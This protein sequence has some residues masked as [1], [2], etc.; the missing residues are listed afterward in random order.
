MT[1]LR[2]VLLLLIGLAATGCAAITEPL[3]MK[4]P[5]AIETPFKDVA[6]NDM[7]LA[8]AIE[9]P[10]VVIDAPQG[11]SEERAV[12]LRNGIVLAARRRDLPASTEPMA[13]AWVLS[14][15]AATISNPDKKG[16]P[17][18]TGVLS[19]RLIDAAGAEKGAFVVSFEGGEAALTETGVRA[20]AEQ[21]ASALEA[22]L[23]RPGTQVTEVAAASVTKPKAWIGAIK[24]APGDGNKALTQALQ[25]ILPLKGVLVETAKDKAQWRIE[26][27]VKVEPSPTQDK[28]TLTWRVL[29]AKGKEAG[30]IKQENAVPHGRLSKP[31]AE[32]AGF[33]AEAA[34][35]GI[36][37]LIQQVTKAKTA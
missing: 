9:V 31:W 37:Q 8:Q 16:A 12:A 27:V 6:R 18:E 19:W 34:A 26:G 15:Q 17:R 4:D 7:M 10:A 28:V 24:G 29:D 14:A 35:E 22:A 25:G 36:A 1:G 33:A 11:L 20:V 13:M 3:G 2:A 32:I 21:T 30:T 5:F 23:A